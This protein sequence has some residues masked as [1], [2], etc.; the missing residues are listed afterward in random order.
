MHTLRKILRFIVE[1][2]DLL[3]WCAVRNDLAMGLNPPSRFE[4][5]FAVVF[6][7]FWIGF[8]IFSLLAWCLGMWEIIQW[9][10]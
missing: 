3:Y 6:V 2:E 4:I 1:F 10:F 8:I 5:L 9:V 7:L